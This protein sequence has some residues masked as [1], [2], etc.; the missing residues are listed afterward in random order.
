MRPGQLEHDKLRAELPESA[1]CVDDCPFCA[2]SREKASKEE[3]V[4]D[5][6]KVYDQETLDALLES[7]R[8]K[9]ADEARKESEDEL[10]Q[11]QAALAEK[12]DEL[13]TAN[14]RIEELEGEIEKRDEEERLEELADERKSQVAEVTDLTDEQL[15]EH[16]AGWAKMSEED[17]EVRLSELKAVTESAR[18][19]SDP[20]GKKK[21]ASKAP[22][23]KLDGTRETAGKTGTDTE[24]L[25]SF[26]TGASS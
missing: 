3:K 22:A 16:K 7:A 4:S 15:E 20:K 6:G 10:A 1:E 13:A 19:Q 14:S 12:D 21:E 11:A 25:R 8:E 17:F 9:A 23:S 2:D 5:N 24:R 26:L 18:A